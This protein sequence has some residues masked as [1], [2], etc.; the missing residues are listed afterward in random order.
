MMCLWA[1]NMKKKI[2]FASLQSMKRSRIQSWI[3][4][5]IH[6]LEVWIRGSGSASA[7]KCYG[8]PTLASMST[9][10]WFLFSF[11]DH[12]ATEGG[13]TAEHYC[14]SERVQLS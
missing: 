1:S 12:K 11:R 7:P 4:I 3:R 6:L 2:F 8:S 13:G 10:N 5:W 14:A 9:P